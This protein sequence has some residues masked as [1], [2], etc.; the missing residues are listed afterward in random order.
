MKVKFSHF[1]N[2][3]AW[4]IRVLSVGEPVSDVRPPLLMLKRREFRG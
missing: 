2:G 1:F 3:N 4:V